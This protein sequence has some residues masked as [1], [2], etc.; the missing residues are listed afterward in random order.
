[1]RQVK[2]ILKIWIGI[3][4]ALL[5][6]PVL[7]Y[8]IRFSY[9][10]LSE[11]PVDWTNFSVYLSNIMNPML[12]CINIILLIKLT[13]EVAS[14]NE[15]NVRNDMRQR[16]YTDITKS[17]FSLTSILRSSNN[18]HVDLVILRN[19]VIL[20]SNTMKHLF[21]F[22]GFEDLTDN[23]DN[24]LMKLA[25]SNFIKNDMI[26]NEDTPES[27]EFLVFFEE[28]DLIRKEFINSLQKSI[29]N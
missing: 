2:R 14:F 3:I 4:V 13:Y 16:A 10:P 1:M 5:I 7:L 12:L 23:L 6:L 28:F 17:L 11:N 21:D 24:S 18:K 25:D 15:K 20:F 22:E 29:L 27:K 9:L 26:F 8:I 19:D